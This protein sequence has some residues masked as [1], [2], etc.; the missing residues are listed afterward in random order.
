MTKKTGRQNKKSKKSAESEKKTKK[1]G[2]KQILKGIDQIRFFWSRFHANRIGIGLTVLFFLYI[3]YCALTLPDIEKAVKATRAPQITILAA[4]GTEIA[5]YGAQ[6]G[7]PV[8]LKRLPDYVPQAVIAT[9]DR[10]FYSHFGVDFRSVFRA[11]TVNLIKRR[12]A[13]G[14]SKIGRAHV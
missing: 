2:K 1:R 14:A 13:Q 5:S 10:R 12:K 11:A 9:E 6:S 3:G 4:D 7:H 8:E